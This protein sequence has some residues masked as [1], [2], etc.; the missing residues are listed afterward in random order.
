M[1]DA[2]KQ[3]SLAAAACAR[4]RGGIAAGV[5]PILASLTMVPV[6]AM[7][8][9]HAGE[10]PGDAEQP[11]DMAF[12]EYLGSWEEDDSDW[13]ALAGTAPEASE[14]RQPSA[15]RDKGEE[16]GTDEDTG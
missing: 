7:T 11:H 14:G 12:I 3:R 13:I 15:E 1:A 4:R 2:A 8:P 6:A 5:L 9:A 16:N 10:S